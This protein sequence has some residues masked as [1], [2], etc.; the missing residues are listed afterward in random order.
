MNRP[1]KIFMWLIAVLT[2]IVICAAFYYRRFLEMEIS[3]VISAYGLLA[4]A[5]LVFILDF[6][7]Q[8]LSSY[9]VLISGLAFGLNP[10]ITCAFAIIASSTSAILAYEIGKRSSRRFVKSVV[11]KKDFED[12]S[13][14]INR[15]GKWIVFASALSPIP[16]F[17][18][19][20]GALGLQKEKFYYY[21]LV[22]RAAGFIAIT[23][24][25]IFLPEYIRL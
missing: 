7:P 6:F 10:I 13:K 23:I 17:P 9:L 15:W 12:M 25:F 14:G 19:L 1:Y 3:A 21:G 5:L 4:V 20:F 18:L 2:I 16:Y 11:E 8:Y 24:M 22:P